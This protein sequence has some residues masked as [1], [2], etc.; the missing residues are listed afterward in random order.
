MLIKHDSLCSNTMYFYN[1]LK[2]SL[3]CNSRAVGLVLSCLIL[4]VVIC[5]FLGLLLGVAGL[6]P[7]YNPTERSGTSNCGGIFFMA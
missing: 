1:N 3:F 4:L 6:N 7:K 5:N 2:Q